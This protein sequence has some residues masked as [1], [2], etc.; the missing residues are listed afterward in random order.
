MNGSHIL[1]RILYFKVLN[2][3]HYTFIIFIFD[4]IIYYYKIKNINL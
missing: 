4:T 1:N 3:A 2:N